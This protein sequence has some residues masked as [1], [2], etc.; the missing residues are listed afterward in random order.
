MGSVSTSL[1][2]RE[3]TPRLLKFLPGPGR[4]TKPTDHLAV[5]DSAGRTELLGLFPGM[6]PQQLKEKYDRLG[7]VEPMQIAFQIDEGN[8]PAYQSLFGS[9]WPGKCMLHTGDVEATGRQTICARVRYALNHNY[10]RPIAKTGFHYF[11]AVNTRGVRGFETEFATIREMVMGQH[12]PSELV[13]VVSALR[14]PF[15]HRL[16]DR[17]RLPFS[18]LQ[19]KQDEGMAEASVLMFAREGHPNPTPYRISLGQIKSAVI[20]R[21]ARMA[22][23]YVVDDSLGPNVTGAVVA[24]SPAVPIE[25]SPLADEDAGQEYPNSFQ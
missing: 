22:H 25:D 1:T 16:S 15:P 8:E 13:S 5:T 14:M 20:A 23:M 12:D 18:Y 21:P 2:R 3:E 11:L 4:N 7:L 6:R 9:V 19:L 10:L 24:T 17:I